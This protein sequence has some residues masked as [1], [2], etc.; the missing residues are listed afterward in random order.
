VAILHVAPYKSPDLCPGT[1]RG[2]CRYAQGQG[3]SR[4]G[5]LLELQGR[6]LLLRNLNGDCI[7]QGTSQVQADTKFVEAREPSAIL[8]DS[9]S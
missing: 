2:K 6:S 3:I 5:G 8:Q 7:R 9:G 4:P 1:L